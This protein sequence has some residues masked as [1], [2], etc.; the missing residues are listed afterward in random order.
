MSSVPTYEV[1]I[2]TSPDF[3]HYI[4]FTA[5]GWEL[6][7][8]EHI[9]YA[10]R[11]R[12]KSKRVKFH[13]ALDKHDPSLWTHQ[14]F[15]FDTEEEALSAEIRLISE[16]NTVVDGYN[17]DI[18]GTSGAL[19]RK[20]T[21]DHK[22]A[23]SEARLR[24]YETE[25]G[26]AYKAELAERMKGND[27][28]KAKKGCKQPIEAIEKARATRIRKIASGEIISIPPEQTPEI[29]AKTKNTKREKKIGWKKYEITHPCGTIEI[30]IGLSEWCRN[31][32]ISGSGASN[33]SQKGRWKQFKCRKIE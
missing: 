12:K 8:K 5:R 14:I 31:N 27:Y 3:K 11:T 18:G 10:K 21:D 20:C 25:A 4:G 2:H 7:W 1:Y 9:L 6:R 24:Y 13:W 26:I 22:L 23:Q 15:S 16:M 17:H 28:G 33:L 30:V 29:I 19:G 32:N